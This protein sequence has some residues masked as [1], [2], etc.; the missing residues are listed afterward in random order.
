MQEWF[1]FLIWFSF[2]RSCSATD[3]WSCAH[4]NTTS[5]NGR[6]IWDVLA[7]GSLA[8]I[9]FAYVVMIDL[10]RNFVVRYG[11]NGNSAIRSNATLS[12]TFWVA[13]VVGIVAAF[14][15]AILA[16]IFN[17]LQLNAQSAIITGVTWQ[18][19]YANLVE[20]ME[21]KLEPN[22]HERRDEPRALVT[23]R[24]EDPAGILATAEADVQTQRFEDAEG[25]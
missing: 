2:E 5:F 23:Q 16:S 11:P 7:F 12:W 1:A 6:H 25:G 14:F 20:M 10:M 24:V 22:S 3:V 4:S 17:I 21:K 13:V 15:V 8:A 19:V 9:G 18:A